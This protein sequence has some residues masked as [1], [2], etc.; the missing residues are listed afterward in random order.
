MSGKM[1]LYKLVVLGEGGVGKVKKVEDWGVIVI[2]TNEIDCS[3]DPGTK[4]K[5]RRCP[6][7]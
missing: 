3:D 2:L 1:T 4:R 6:P 5:I 7:N